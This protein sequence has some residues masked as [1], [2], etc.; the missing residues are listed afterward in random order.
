MGTERAYYEYAG[1][2]PVEGRIL[3]IRPGKGQMAV[4]LERTI[5]YPEGGGQPADRGTI[6]G[7]PLL[8]VWEEGEEI[9]HLM[10]AAEGA[11]LAPGPVEL[12]LDA[13][14]RRDF[15]VAH[16]AQH[17]LSG[18]ILRLTGRSTASM[19]LGE[20]ICT[21]DVEGP[22]FDGEALREVEDAVMD[23]VEEDRPVIIHR[24]PPEDLG[25]FPLRKKPPRGEG[26]IRVVEIQGK[27]FSPCCGTHLGTTGAIGMLR[28]LGAEKYKGMTRI[29]FIAGRRV[30]QESRLLR[31]NGELISRT[32]QA[33]VAGIGEAVLALREKAL[34][35]EGRLKIMEEEA[36]R[37]RAR[38]LLVEAGLSSPDSF[39]KGGPLPGEGLVITRIFEDRTMEELLRTGRAAQV[40]CRAAIVLAAAGEGKFAAFCSQSSLDLRAL[41]KGP[42]AAQGGRG[43]GNASFFQG[44]FPGEEALRAF[45]AALP[46]RFP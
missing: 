14:R 32:L 23:A 12:V 24:C 33:P 46:P 29:T 34:R 16:T 38:E 25:S 42:L 1:A 10:D 45:I 21:I 4:I 41:V 18:T 43:G 17:L 44:L 28:I 19:R 2:G 20:E 15:T 11:A 27:D 30:F 7:R 40:G 9:L 5:F 13:P 26:V 31:R 39:G 8:D 3:E 22:E 6:G 35:L 36:A 37:G